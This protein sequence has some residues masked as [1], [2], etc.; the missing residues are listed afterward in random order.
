MKHILEMRAKREDSKLR[1]KTFMDKI[2][3]ESRSMTDEE[4]KEFEK[5]ESEIRGWDNSISVAERMQGMTAGADGAGEQ[6]ANPIPPNTDPNSSG[7]DTE[8]RSFGEFLGTIIHNPLDERLKRSSGMNEAAPADGGYL[9]QKDFS[10]ELLKQAYDT[11]LLASKVKKVPIKANS[12]GLKIN[13]VDFKNRDTTTGAVTGGVTMGWKGEG[14]SNDASKPKFRQMDLS[15]KKLLGFC[16]ITDELMADTEALETIVRQ[17]FADE[18]GYVIDEAILNG[19][20]TT[21]PK[22]IMK[23]TAL[24][25]LDRKAT[26]GNISTEDIIEMWARLYAKSRNKAVFVVNQLLEAELMT[27]KIGETA[28]YIPAGGLSAKPYGT[29]LGRPVIVLEQ[30]GALGAEG[31]IALI[32]FSQYLAIDKDGVQTAKSIHV[33]FLEDEQVL[34]VTY[35]FDGEPI[36]NSPLKLGKS[37]TTVSPYVTLKAKVVARGGTKQPIQETLNEEP[38]KA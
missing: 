34:R 37:G 1:A 33:K 16:Y 22:G 27:L 7:T 8:F 6:R 14:E 25:K 19:A 2:M 17:A 9:V 28:I 5:F 21:Q 26:V 31:D 3:G 18:I 4:V 11:G 24:I 29:L 35:R 23:S 15:L 36:W 13:V 30:C 10:K 38:P 12:N 32:D 20:G